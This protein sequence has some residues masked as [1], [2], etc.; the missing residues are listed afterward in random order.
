VHRNL[1]AWPGQPDDVAYAKSALQSVSSL[2]CIDAQRVYC[3]GLS[4]GGRLCQR[5]ASELP[6]QAFAAMALFSSVRYPVPNNGTR[7]IPLIAFHGTDDGINPYFGSNLPEYWGPWSVPHEMQRWAG[8]NGC[9]RLTNATRSA[10]CSTNCNDKFASNSGIVYSR[11]T[12]C[13]EGADTELVTILGAGHAW[14]FLTST[15]AT[16]RRVK[17]DNY[18]VPQLDT[19]EEMWRFLSRFPQN[20]PERGSGSKRDG[21]APSMSDARLNQAL[22]VIARSDSPDMMDIS[23]HKDVRLIHNASE[24]GILTLGILQ[25]SWMP[26]WSFAAGVTVVA[27]ATIATVGTLLART[28]CVNKKAVPAIRI[29]EHEFLI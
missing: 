1:R 10:S 11:W 18:Q 3:V 7:P 23:V 29:L 26:K 6:G 13:W 27:V 4:N 2:T 19:T 21:Q 14:P 15:N 9:S 20:G 5:L 8:F 28:M 16:Y 17:D 24:S 25:P 22:L 12:D